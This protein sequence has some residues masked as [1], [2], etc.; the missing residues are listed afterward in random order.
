MEHNIRTIS[1]LPVRRASERIVSFGHIWERKASESAVNAIIYNVY[2]SFE[3]Q[4]LKS[5]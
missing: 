1:K 3:Q 2:K 4:A 5:K